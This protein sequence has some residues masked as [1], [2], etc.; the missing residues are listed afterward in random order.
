M[1]DK[2]STGPLTQ[3]KSTASPHKVYAGASKI[4]K[5]GHSVSVGPASKK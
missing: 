3:S 1:A 4:G 5:S 2:G